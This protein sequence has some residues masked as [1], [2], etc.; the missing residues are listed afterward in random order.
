[1]D[2]EEIFN[3]RKEKAKEASIVLV[4]SLVPLSLKK[5]ATITPLRN[6]IPW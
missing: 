1:M 5:R 6:M 4:A 2:R 3:Q